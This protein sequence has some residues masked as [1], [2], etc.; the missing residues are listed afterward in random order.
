MGGLRVALFIAPSRKIAAWYS[1]RRKRGFLAVGTGRGGEFKLFLL[2]CAAKE[3]LGWKM[4]WSPAV[5]DRASG[6][7]GL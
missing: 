2:W 1:L 5:R 7:I 6:D 4:L 3:E